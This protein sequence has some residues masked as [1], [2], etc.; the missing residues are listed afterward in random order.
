M[1]VEDEHVYHVG[2]LDLLAHNN[3]CGSWVAE[4]L[5]RLQRMRDAY[6]NVSGARTSNGGTV[7]FMEME[8]DGVVKV[9]TGRS[10]HGMSTTFTR[11]NPIT[12]AHAE[13]AVV[14][15]A[16]NRG[17]KNKGTNVH[18]YVDHPPCGA[19]SRCNGIGSLARELGVSYITVHYKD[20]NDTI[21]SLPFYP[22]R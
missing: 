19:C 22:T 11:V 18:I 9:F 14:Q 5:G 12:R 20:I 10:A 4:K 16:L 6:G 7:A 15:D 8:V 13:G 17:Y 1:T 21:H 2:Y 3:G